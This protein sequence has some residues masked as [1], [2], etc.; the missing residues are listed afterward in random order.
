MRRYYCHYCDTSFPYSKDGRKRHLTGHN[1]VKLK[2]AYYLQFSSAQEQLQA[3]L[4]K[5]KCRRFTSGQ[6][7]NYGDTC[8]YSHL[9]PTEIEPLKRLAEKESVIEEY[10][11]LPSMLQNKSLFITKTAHLPFIDSN[12]VAEMLLEKRK[13]NLARELNLPVIDSCVP[14]SSNSGHLTS[15]SCGP[16]VPSLAAGVRLPPSMQMG[17]LDDILASCS[18]QWGW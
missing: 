13:A 8:I 6:G 11:N 12:S 10:G 5:D 16:V 7:C 3:T 17:S 1:H 14:S 18:S 9:T 4:S 2:Q 15:G